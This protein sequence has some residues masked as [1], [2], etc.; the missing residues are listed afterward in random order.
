MANANNTSLPN[1]E[2]RPIPGWEGLY[3]VSNHGRV[4]SLDRVVIRNDGIK[5]TITGR[6]MKPVADRA[7]H[8]YVDL[9]RNNKKHRHYIH[10]AVL[11]AF[12]GPAPE[13]MECCH[14]DGDKENNLLGNLR[15]DDRSGNVMDMVRSGVHHN[16]RKTHCKRG[17][18]FTP[19][20]TK[21]EVRPTTTVRICR[22]CT[23]MRQQRYA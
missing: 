12:V 18:E 14:W 4:R 7:G 21:V 19:E 13:R 5:R 16:A 8:L 1:E 23:R 2:W 11:E 9:Y 6:T 10:R 3:D 17:H 22:E 15:W 20:N